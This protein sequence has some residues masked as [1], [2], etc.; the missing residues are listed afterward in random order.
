MLG[1]CSEETKEFL[2]KAIKEGGIY[3]S[4][5]H[6]I[7]KLSPPAIKMVT[8]DNPYGKTTKKSNG[9]ISRLMTTLL[10]Q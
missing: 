1:N 4:P 6:P 3:T 8:M 10:R 9:L 7:G 5:L 2:K